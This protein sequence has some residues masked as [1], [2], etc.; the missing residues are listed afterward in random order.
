[1]IGYLDEFTASSEAEISAMEAERGCRDMKMAEYMEDFVGE[2]FDAIVSSVTSFGMF[3]ELENTVE[4]LVSMVDI[5]DDYYIYDDK[6]KTL[7]GERKGKIYRIGDKVKVTLIKADKDS[8][9]IDF[10]CGSLNDQHLRR[11]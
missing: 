3:V 11:F 6:S 4:G 7:T 8:R 5:T 1:M 2:T 10:A 9:R